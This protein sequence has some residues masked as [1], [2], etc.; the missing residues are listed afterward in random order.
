MIFLTAILYPFACV[1]SIL[2]TVLSYLILNRFL[3]MFGDADGNLPKCLIWFQTFDAT[4]YQGQYARKA[5]LLMN[6]PG[7]D[8]TDFNPAPVTWYERYKNRFAWLQR[9]PAYG[10][11]FYPFGLE[12]NPADWRVVHYVSTTDYV[13]FIAVGRGF[14]LYYAGPYGTYKLGWKAWNNFDAATGKLG[15]TF[16]DGTRVPLCFTPEPWEKK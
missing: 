11:D 15:S 12:W 8:W 9:N 14:N 7:S 4:M 3:A 10:W 6:P 13:L 16:G 1:G 2:V 5:E